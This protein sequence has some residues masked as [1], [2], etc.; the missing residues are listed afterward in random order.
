[1]RTG[2]LPRSKGEDKKK[3]RE[4]DFRGSYLSYDIF[5]SVF[6][7]IALRIKA[8]APCMCKKM[9]ILSCV[10]MTKQTA[11]IRAFSYG[12]TK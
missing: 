12:N 9:K 11:R 3:P 8:G 2:Y 4:S 7:D 10:C 1:M 5:R 6:G